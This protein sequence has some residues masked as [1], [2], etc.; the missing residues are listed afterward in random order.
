M[1]N[2]AGRERLKHT[3]LAGGIWLFL[4]LIGSAVMAVT[5]PPSVSVLLGLVW[6]GATVL[7]CIELKFR[8]DMRAGVY[9]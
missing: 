8:L 9:L 7:A 3:A 2:A 5:A 6:G 4:V 1:A